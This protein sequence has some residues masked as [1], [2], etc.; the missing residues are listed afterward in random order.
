MK[1][2]TFQKR[3]TEAH[4]EQCSE[5]TEQSNPKAGGVQ[6]SCVFGLSKREQASLLHGYRI[7]FLEKNALGH[8]FLESMVICDGFHH[9]TAA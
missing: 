8:A 5:E 4:A 1:R 6:I 7:S 9:F 3:E 2:S